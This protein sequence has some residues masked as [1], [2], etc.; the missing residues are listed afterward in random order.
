MAYRA[1]FINAKDFLV[2]F[3]KSRIKLFWYKLWIRKNEF[4]VSLDMDRD[5]LLSSNEK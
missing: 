3:L 1:E 4:H 5:F 2:R